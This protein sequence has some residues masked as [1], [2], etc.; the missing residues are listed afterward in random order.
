[1]CISSLC[2]GGFTGKW[3]GGCDNV[4]FQQQDRIDT[5]VLGD[6]SRHAANC[7]FHI[8]LHLLLAPNNTYSSMHKSWQIYT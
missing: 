5:W 7:P 2:L 1:M 4:I 3:P 8:Q 6:L